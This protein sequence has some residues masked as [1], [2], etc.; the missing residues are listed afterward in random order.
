MILLNKNTTLETKRNKIFTEIDSLQQFEYA[1]SQKLDALTKQLAA[2]TDKQNKLEEKI[3]DL[4][5]V[6]ED[7]DKI[8]YIKK[9]KNFDLHFLA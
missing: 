7:P 3:M 8:E 6:L 4:K 9:Q 5:T 2:L 1:R